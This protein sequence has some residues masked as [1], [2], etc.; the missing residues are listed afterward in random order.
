MSGS[1]KGYFNLLEIYFKFSYSVLEEIQLIKIHN[2]FCYKSFD[3]T[4]LIFAFSYI[5]KPFYSMLML[6]KEGY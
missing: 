6:S 4:N 3:S 1:R 2:I 5:I